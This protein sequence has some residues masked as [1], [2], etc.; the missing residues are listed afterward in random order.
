MTGKP[1]ATSK[2]LSKMT[3]TQ[4]KNV[5]A[6][7]EASVKKWKARQAAA[8]AQLARLNAKVSKLAGRNRG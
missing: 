5:V 8:K 2:T 6:Q 3:L 4:L 7:R 1:S